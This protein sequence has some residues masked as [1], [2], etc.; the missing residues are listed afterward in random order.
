MTAGHSERPIVILNM[1]Y[2]GLA[3][4]RDLW[5]PGRSIYGLSSNAEFFG[6]AS[7]YISFQLFPDTETAPE[8]CLRFLMELSEQCAQKPILLPTRDH[9]I[10]FIVKYR[11]TIEDGFLVP[12]AS[13]DVLANIVDKTALARIAE[14]NEL[15]CPQSFEIDNRDGLSALAGKLEFPCLIK[16]VVATDWRKTGIR[17][18]VEKRKAIKTDT[19]DELVRCYETVEPYQPK[20]CIQE[21]IEGPESNLVIFG[22]YCD[23]HSDVLAH[24]TGR[25]LLQYPA[26]AGTGVAVEATPIPEIVEQSSRLLKSLKYFGVSEIEYKLDERRKRYALIEINSR[27]WDQHGLGSAVGVNLSET[28]YA[29]VCGARVASRQQLPQSK[30]W[31]AEDGILLSLASNLRHKSYHWSLYWQV[32]RSPKY[33]AV[34][35]ASDL[36]P[37]L[38]QITASV[39]GTAGRILRRIGR[40]FRSA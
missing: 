2:T 32:L 21:Y 15:Y 4:A 20:A 33:F 7:R 28:M 35:S 10:H 29:D 18:V 23:E 12:Y 19:F 27:H 16:P 1:H 30:I 22:S 3:I 9:D 40:V 39:L 26:G 11:K 17:D 24:F 8:E 31:L 14:E 34:W 5:K 36:R 38:R 13:N 37:G 6:N 25:K